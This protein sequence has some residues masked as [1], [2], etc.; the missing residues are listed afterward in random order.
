MTDL[1]W[2]TQESCIGIYEL[3]YEGHHY[4]CCM[5]ESNDFYTLVKDRSIKKLWDEYKIT[6]LIDSSLVVG[7][8]ETKKAAA[9]FI[10]SRAKSDRYQ[11]LT[12]DN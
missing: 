2:K 1:K 3:D 7:I 5:N 11:P 12:Q 9:G 6:D 8:F 10:K 4:E